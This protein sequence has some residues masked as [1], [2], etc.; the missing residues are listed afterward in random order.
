[1]PTLRIDLGY[2][3]YNDDYAESYTDVPRRVGQFTLGMDQVIYS[4]DLVTN[5]IVK[6]KKL[7]FEKA[8]KV[9]IIETDMDD[10]MQKAA[11]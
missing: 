6:H 5:I 8:E 7:K 2:Q 9:L 10:D 3:K 11:I 4:P 1:M